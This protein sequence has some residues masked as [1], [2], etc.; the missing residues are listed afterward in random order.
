[1][2]FLQ[3]GTDC[4]VSFLEIDKERHCGAFLSGEKGESVSAAV[5]G[6]HTFSFILHLKIYL[7]QS[8]IFEHL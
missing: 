2:H 5:T 7:F 8:I 4:T 3:V 6:M 1:M